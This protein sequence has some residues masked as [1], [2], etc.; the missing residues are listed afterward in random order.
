V[1]R[2]YLV[3]KGLYVSVEEGI[4]GSHREKAR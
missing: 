3:V 2:P 1:K 4:Q